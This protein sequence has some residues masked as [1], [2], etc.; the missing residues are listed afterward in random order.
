MTD[1]KN[2]FGLTDAQY[3][4]FEGITGDLEVVQDG[5]I[6]GENSWISLRGPAGTGKTF[7]SLSIVQTLLDKNMTIAVLAPTHQAVKVI[8]NTINI[9]HKNIVYSTLHAFLGLKP[10]DIDPKTG[11]RKFKKVTGKN[12]SPLS[13]MKVDVVILDESSMVGEELFNFLKKE[14]YENNRIKSFLFIGDSCQLM[15]V[16]TDSA[17][18]NYQHPVYNNNMINHYNLTELIRNDDP[19]VINFV[20]VIRKMIE[21]GASKFEMFNFL[22]N[23]AEKQDEFKKIHFFRNKKEFMTKYLEDDRVGSTEGCIA[24]FTNENVQKYNGLFRDYFIKKKHPD[25]IEV[26]DLHRDDLLVVQSGNEDFINSE[27]LRLRMFV[28]KEYDFKGKKFQGYFC[29]TM[30]GRSFNYI[31][32]ES[33]A[34]YEYAL[35]LLKENAIKAKTRAAWLMY[36]ELI[37]L[38]LEVRFHYAYTCHKLQGSSYNEIYVDMTGLGYVQS[39]M[40][41]RLFYVACTRSRGHINILI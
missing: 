28:K 31:A 38:F 21:T 19:E 6:F 23:S 12:A 4:A 34:D 39:S 1:N 13:K 30:D 16:E 29:T 32:K 37:E 22:V 25:I 10:G 33:E 24:T 2:K 15:P 8:K 7:L 18:D 9:E 41:L 14:M 27:I 3:S 11:E 40:L 36:Y 17:L 35:A 5:D 26:P 20:T